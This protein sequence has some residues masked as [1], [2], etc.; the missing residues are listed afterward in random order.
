M[1]ASRMKKGQI[2]A[3]G[4][5]FGQLYPSSATIGTGTTGSVCGRGCCINW[6]E[7][8]G[9]WKKNREKRRIPVAPIS[10]KPRAWLT[11]R[12][13]TRNTKKVIALVSKRL[14][15]LIH[16]MSFFTEPTCEAFSLHSPLCKSIH[17]CWQL[18]F[19]VTKYTTWNKKT[20]IRRKMD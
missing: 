14:T 2:V 4:A 9:F 12:R 20:S 19:C 15:S 1:Y 5:P 10:W 18:P 17:D 16:F 8:F 13:E 3:L 7:R 11:R 6:F